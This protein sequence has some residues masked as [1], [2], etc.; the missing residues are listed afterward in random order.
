[1]S[2]AI[3]N[4]ATSLYLAQVGLVRA[5]S[6]VAFANA[7]LDSDKVFR[8]LVGNKRPSSGSTAHD[9]PPPSVTAAR[10]ILTQPPIV[11]SIGMKLKLIPAG[12]FQMGD[13]RGRPDE[14]PAH[15]VTITKPF[16]LGVYEVT[17]TQWKKVMPNIDT[18][19]PW[20][21]SE[22]Q[23]GDRPVL[24]VS[25]G[26]TTEFCR[27]LSAVPEEVKAGRVY[28]LPTEAEWEYACRAGTRTEFSFGNDNYLL[29]DYGWFG[30]NAGGQTHPV[31]QK[32]PNPWGLY[33]MHGNVWELCSDWFGSYSKDKV[34]DPQ[35]AP[36]GPDG[37]FRGGGLASHAETCSSTTRG[38]G[39]VRN[40][41]VG[42][43]LVMN[44]ASP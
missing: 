3:R 27:L 43:R 15:E 18:Y 23:E 12:T 24:H 1:M 13:D 17:N 33:D 10:N 21:C 40:K 32:K 8:E 30:G 20:D 29:G 37:V 11:N 41:F 28:R 34:L 25:W 22:M 14:R 44:L 4:H 7:W 39:S 16:Y 2:E 6:D 38:T 42:F 26:R 9:A 36:E 19:S 5:E 35:G 31:G